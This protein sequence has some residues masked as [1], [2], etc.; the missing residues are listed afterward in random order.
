MMLAGNFGEVTSFSKISDTEGGFTA[1]LDDIDLFGNAVSEIGDLDGD[2]VRDIA[3]AATG[4]DDGGNARGAVYILLMNADG[5]VKSHQK[6]SDTAGGFTGVL[7]DLDAFGSSLLNLGDL[8]GDGVNDLAV[9]A[10]QD[11]DG[12]SAR[13]A[14]YILFLNSNGTVKSHQ[15]ISDTTGGFTAVLDDTDNFGDALANLGDMDGDGVTE[16]AVSAFRDGDGGTDRGAVYVLFMNTDGTVKSHQKISDTAG[17]F[18]GT[19]DDVDFFGHAMGSLGDLDGDGVTDL[20]VGAVF[21][22][23]GGSGRGAVYVLFLNDDG[24]V[25]SHRK[26][27]NTVG[28]FS[29]ALLD[30]D[31]FGRSLANMGDLNGDG[32]TD[33]AVGAYGDD[34]G[35]GQRG[36]VY[37]LFLNSDGSVKSHQKISDTA[38]N[39]TATLDN[40]DFFGVM[41][42]NLGDLDG[43]G[44]VELVVGANQDDDGGNARGAVYILSLEQV[45]PSGVVTSSNKISDIAGGF[46]GGLGGFDYFGRS[47]TELGDLDGDG[48]TDFAVGADADDDGGDARGAVYILFMN[49][50]GTVKSHQKISSTAGGFIATLDNFDRFGV[51]LTNLGDLDGDDVVD[52]AV[53]VRGDDDGGEARGAVYVLFL[54]TDGTVKSHQKISDTEGGFTGVLENLDNF[55][56]SLTSIEDLNGDGIADLT[57]GARF[58]HDGGDNRGAIYVLFL[59]TDG[60]VKSHQKVSDIAG[61]FTGSLDDSDFFGSS[62]TNLGDL[63]GDG[64]ADLAVGA[65]GDDDGGSSRGAV[66]VLFLNADG[67]V[68]SHQKISEIDGGFTASLDDSDFFGVALANLGDLDGDGIEDLMVGANGDDDGGS[69]RGAVYVL[70]LNPDGT[71]K[72]H[73]ILSDTQ[74]NF[75]ATLDDGDGFGSS[76]T[77]LGDLDGDGLPEIVVGA[78][79]DDD[80]GLSAGAVHILSLEQIIPPGVVTAERKISATSGGFTALLGNGDYLGGSVTDLGDLDGDGIPDLAVGASSDD[81]GGSGRGAIYILLMNA[82]GTVKSHQKVSD[83]QG[84]FTALLDD[85]DN[86][87]SSLTN[88]GDLDGDGIT[89]IAVSAD[90]DS[91]GSSNGGALY[92]LFLN[93][94]GTVK[95]FQKITEGVGGFTGNLDTFD[96]FG[97]AVSNIGDL[98]GDGIIDIAVG[99][100]NDDDGGSGRGAIYVLFLNTD[101][102]VKSHQKISSTAGDLTA[103]LDNSDSFGR[104]LTSL[105]D[106]DGDGVTD[107]AVGTNRDDDGGTSRGAVYILFLNTDGTIKSHQKISDLEGGFTGALN[108]TDYFGW[109][110]AALGDLDGD[111][112]TDLAVGALFDDDG[113]L[114]STGAVYVLF[115]NADGTVK[116]H[117]KISHTQGNFTAALGFGDFFGTSLTNMGDLDGDGLIELAVGARGDDDGTGNAGAVYILSLQQ[118]TPPG[119]VTAEQKISDTV[120]GFTAVLDNNDGFGEAVADVGD[121]NGD[122]INDLVVGAR[123]DGDGGSTRGAVYV[124]FLNADGTVNSHQKISSTQGGFTATLDDGDNFG[125][126]IA[127]LGDL[128]GDSITEI[129]VGARLDDD[130]GDAR[131]AVYVLFLN[132][133]GTVKSHQKI[134]DTEGGFTGILQNTDIFGS[135]VA[136]VGDMNGDGVTDLAVGT[137][138][139]DDG[140]NNRG[141]VYLLFLNTDGTVDSHQKISLLEGGFTGTLDESD[142]FGLSLANLGDLDGDGVTD[143]AVG[144]DEDDDAGSDR[145][146]VYV[147]FLRADGTVKSHRK[148]SDTVGNFTGHLNDFDRFGNSL[149]NLGDLD[150]DGVTDLG[151]GAVGDDD[152]GDF[153]GAMNVLFLNTDGTVKSHRKI[154]DTQGNF[155]ATL[156][157][158]DIFGSSLT[159]IADNNGDGIRELVVGATGDDDGGSARGAVYVLSLKGIVVPSVRIVDD[160]DPGF[161]IES[162]IWGT[163]NV[164]ANGDNRNASIFGGTKVAR[165]TFTGLIPGLYRISTTW[166]ESPARA[167]DAPYTI[168]DGANAVSTVDV[169]QQLAP[170]GSGDLTDL[171]VPWQDLESAIPITSDTLFVKLTNVADG[172]VMA[173]AIRIERIDHLPPPPVI[174]DDGDSGFAI[175]SGSWGT[176]SAGAEGDNRNAS[177]FG[178]K[179]VARWTFT[180]LLPGLYRISTT[181]S[182]SPA[183]ATDAPYTIFD[184]FSPITTV[185]VNQ[186]LAPSGSSD[187]TDLGVVWQDL[188]SAIAITNGTLFVKLSNVANGYVMADAI[189]IERVGDIPPPPRIIDDG[190]L[191]FA[192]E[193]GSWG[194]GNGGFDGDNRNASIFGGSKIASWTFTGLS[195]G[196]YR[197]SAT[198]SPSPA[199]ATDAPYTIFNGDAPLTTVDINQQQAPNDFTDAGSSW[200]DLTTVMVTGDTLVVRLSNDANGYVMADAIRIERVLI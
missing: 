139:D 2:G 67:T 8:D 92:V 86:F 176:G 199:R 79:G 106:L 102:T 146:A 147:L 15:K 45:T 183:R 95:S 125:T 34:D 135:A 50:D 27:S 168:F 133:D 170:S 126:S 83:T 75:T 119:V 87:G 103:T 89:D 162:G 51:S 121:L 19:L 194:T 143:L 65:T 30:F 148:I 43:D 192:I 96:G 181:W 62:L 191:G 173:D 99:A 49:S 22:D 164:G 111:G 3:V 69:G 117:Q 6:I 156:N 128:D 47:V 84:N 57:V 114:I 82:D 171:G 101:G 154:S 7:D 37:V 107:V 29:A 198:W 177:I 63:N 165:W 158:T 180:D 110:V 66:Y 130:G 108:D 18:T 141:A 76:I 123:R 189:R 48:V 85:F 11:D 140:G 118:I 100:Y 77:K 185:D 12:G 187:L 61:G 98:D 71:V 109:S 54:N 138:L 97:T 53:G 9:G 182:P 70:F 113:G 72:R 24:T 42:T 13:G 91:D 39:F 166:T 136:N 179:K 17:G 174:L 41:M 36:A 120:G 169:N 56:T 10:D 78:I 73:Q 161:A 58:D 115:L 190:G 52:L 184:G 129:A 131:G 150:G 1:V 55:G 4:D 44:L 160:G 178:G 94:D 28:G 33:L 196:T 127:S 104:S 40:S 46:T 31:F 23:D 193:S 81:E 172:Y 200:E 151:V 188:E 175:E 124:L 20:A 152:G 90:R 145:G 16:L 186:R 153:R 157:D 137:Y 122:G 144:A 59:N 64:L 159:T 167:T 149:T 68:N 142:H 26:I 88:L 60:T 80:G 32:V 105:G 116:A 25:K 197:V 74:G 134:S 35:G 93:S 195:A 132:S 155:N 163:G 5:T 112:L 14:L 21:D 38:G